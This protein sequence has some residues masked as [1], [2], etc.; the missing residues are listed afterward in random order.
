MT[1]FHV[2]PRYST[3]SLWSADLEL[4]APGGIPAS[5]AACRGFTDDH[6]AIG[7]GKLSGHSKCGSWVGKTPRHDRIVPPLPCGISNQLL[8]VDG[9]GCRSRFP[10]QRDDGSLQGVNPLG[11]TVH[12]RDLHGRSSERDDKSG[13]P[14]SRTQ[15]EHRRDVSG[16]RSNEI[17]GMVDDLRNRSRTKGA[18]DLRPFKHCAEA[19]VVAG[20]CHQP[21]VGRGVWGE[22]PGE[23]WVR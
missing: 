4:L 22:L 1:V 18:L 8:G 10:A 19:L 23:G 16:E 3:E 21:S 13:N 2:E 15:I 12:H 20:W 9:D 7:S 14:R 5:W 6:P 11:T 17:I